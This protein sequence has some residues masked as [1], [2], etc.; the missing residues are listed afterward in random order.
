MK[1]NRND[2]SSSIPVLKPADIAPATVAVLT[3]N[4]VEEREFDNGKRLQLTFAEFP[5]HVYYLN[6]TGIDA[7]EEVLGNDTEDWETKIPLV[8]VKARNPQTKKDQDVL[9]VADPKD[10]DELIAGKRPGS[11]RK[12]GRGK[13]TRR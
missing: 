3:C 11:R 2:F 4:G 1:V 7:I 9:H 5:E 8:V 12:S 13:A 10:W 6:V